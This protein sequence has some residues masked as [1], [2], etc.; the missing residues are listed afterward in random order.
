METNPHNAAL[1]RMII[2]LAKELKLEVVAEGAENAAQADMLAQ[3]GCDLIQGYYY[4][5][6]M[7]IADYQA[8]LTDELGIRTA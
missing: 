4:F 3:L 7:A 6:P 5:K 1:V 2:S 8:V